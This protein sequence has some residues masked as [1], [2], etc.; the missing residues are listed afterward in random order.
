MFARF[1]EW[2]LKS[3]STNLPK[4]L[5]GQQIQVK[6]GKGNRKNKIE[7][8]II[9]AISSIFSAYIHKH[10]LHSDLQSKSSSVCQTATVVVVIKFTSCDVWS[11]SLFLNNRKQLKHDVRSGD[12]GDVLGSENW[13]YHKQ[14]S[15]HCPILF[16][17]FVKINWKVKG[18]AMESFSRWPG[19][20]HWPIPLLVKCGV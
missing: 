8:K 11:V 4:S 1:E 9:S 18:F 13:S 15:T 6:V 14:I 3:N 16:T 5:G 20:L 12:Q 17:T 19:M 7:I 10:F 2:I